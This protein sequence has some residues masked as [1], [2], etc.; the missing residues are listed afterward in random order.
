MCIMYK[1]GIYAIKRR[2]V[3]SSFCVSSYTYITYDCSKPLLLENFG[4][5]YRLSKL[6]FKRVQLTL[7]L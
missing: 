7:E 6:I 4:L 2:S 5:S 1:T 3:K